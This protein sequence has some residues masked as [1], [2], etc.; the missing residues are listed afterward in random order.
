MRITKIHVTGLFGVF[1]HTIPLNGEDRI[2]IIYGQNGYGKT[3]TLMLVFELLTGSADSYEHIAEIPFGTIALTCD[4]DSI[5]SV[6]RHDDEDGVVLDFEY[7]LPD[8]SVC[9]QFMWSQNAEEQLKEPPWLVELKLAVTVRLFNTEQLNRGEVRMD[10]NGVPILTDYGTDIQKFLQYR[11]TEYIKLSRKLDSDFSENMDH[12]EEQEID[13]EALGGRLEVMR[14][15]NDRLVAAGVLEEGEIRMD[16][17]SDMLEINP[18]V[19]AVYLDDNEQK[20]AV[21]D[22]FIERIELLQNIVNRRLNHKSMIIDSEAGF[23]FTTSQGKKLT[24][25]QLSS[26]EQRLV[27]LMFKLL[28]GV[29]P[30]TLVLIDEP[31]LS[32]HIAWQQEFLLDLDSIINMVGFDAVVATHS[33]QIIHDRWDLTVELKDLRA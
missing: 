20:L 11:Q 13:I 32:F 9:E 12:A 24:I 18:R 10:E 2:T 17:M 21:F 3:Y 1:D 28:F 19:M 27:M 4:D 16:V 15:K 23:V 7:C 14:A 31:E 5:L 8:G 6:I 26:G 29:Q 22:M 25:D 33:P 30:D